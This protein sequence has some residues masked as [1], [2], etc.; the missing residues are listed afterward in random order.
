MTAPSTIHGLAASLVCVGTNAFPALAQ[1]LHSQAARRA[2][3][4]QAAPGILE[5]LGDHG[6]ERFGEKDNTNELAV[7]QAWISHRIGTES[8]QGSPPSFDTLFAQLLD[9]DETQVWPPARIEV[10]E[11][12]LVKDGKRVS[13]GAAFE[14]L[15]ARKWSARKAT[16]PSLLFVKG[17]VSVATLTGTSTVDFGA[18]DLSETEAAR[19]DAAHRSY[20]DAQQVLQSI[21]IPDVSPSCK[22][23]LESIAII[24]TWIEQPSSDPVVS[25][26]QSELKNNCP[27]LTDTKLWQTAVERADTLQSTARSE[28]ETLSRKPRYILRAF[29][30]KTPIPEGRTEAE[31]EPNKR[32][33]SYTVVRRFGKAEGTS[34]FSVLADDGVCW[35]ARAADIK[36]TVVESMW[37]CCSDDDECRP[38]IYSNGSALES[39][40]DAGINTVVADPEDDIY[41]DICLE[42]TSWSYDQ[43]IICDGCER[44]VHQMCHVPVVTEDE[45]TQDQWFCRDCV[46]K[47]TKDKGDAAVKRQRTG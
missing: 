29:I 10:S 17:P 14:K 33:D 38:A 35:A 30:V 41:C 32:S 8:P 27:L 24:R 42:L 28:L 3:D 5:V 9:P 40:K 25:Q 37:V 46:H 16:P 44:G 47:M 12:E 45:L 43:I 34:H 13:D 7:L 31:S 22:A 15:L 11:I 39:V 1:R 18:S 23:L 2:T 21:G 4:S 36:G 6:G 26:A 20:S 19:L